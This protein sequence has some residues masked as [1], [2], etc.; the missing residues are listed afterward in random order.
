MTDDQ[1]GH[2]LTQPEG[3][4]QGGGLLRT[5]IGM[6]GDGDRGLGSDAAGEHDHPE[7]EPSRFHSVTHRHWM[8]KTSRERE[9]Q[10]AADGDR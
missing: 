6:P 9:K 5:T 10:V 2:G 7:G 3:S 8:K 1:G 4:Q